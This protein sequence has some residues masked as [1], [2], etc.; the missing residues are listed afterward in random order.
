[1][2][3]NC[4]ENQ[5]IEEN[6]EESDDIR[7]HE[8]TDSHIQNPFNQMS[9]DF[10]DEQ[11]F[12]YELIDM[13]LKRYQKYSLSLFFTFLLL[14][15]NFLGFVP[16][17]CVVFPLVFLEILMVFE[18][19]FKYSAE[20]ELIPSILNSEYIRDIV[21]SLGNLGTYGVILLYLLNSSIF[22]VFV[23]VPLF[24]AACLRFLFKTSSM[25]PCLSFSE[26]VNFK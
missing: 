5:K 20:R 2:E 18:A 17:F 6:D 22:L 15:L 12:D 10:E 1:M 3:K 7:E 24:L 19:F 13:A 9:T 21:D 26:I 11:E 16:A 25:S 8:D 4:V 23:T 14:Q